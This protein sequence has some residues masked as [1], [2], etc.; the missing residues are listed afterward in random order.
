MAIYTAEILWQ[1]G[2]QNFL[3]K[4]YSRKHLIKLDGGLE[5]PASSSPQVVPLPYSDATAADPEELMVA[6]LANCHMLFF[7]SIA[8]KRGFRVDSYSDNAAGFM[9]KNEKGKLFLS[10][11]VLNPLVLFSGEKLP[12]Q[13]EIKNMHHEAHE[14]CFIA[15]SVITKISC[16]PLFAEALSAEDK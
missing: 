9:T 13:D 3:D 11:V 4:R 14:E 7:L 5:I 1:R 15:N 12:S 16:K 10:E 2:D 8:A 6:A